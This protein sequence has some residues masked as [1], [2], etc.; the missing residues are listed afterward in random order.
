MPNEQDERPSARQVT[1]PVQPGAPPP[2]TDYASMES[3]ELFQQAM[4]PDRAA[5]AEFALKR[6]PLLALQGGGQRVEAQLRSLAAKLEAAGQAEQESLRLVYL[7]I[8]LL[9]WY[10]TRYGE[11]AE[12][13]QTASHLVKRAD[14]RAADLV[15]TDRTRVAK[16]IASEANRALAL[17]QVGMETHEIR[18][19]FAE[20]LSV[21]LPDKTP[22]DRLSFGALNYCA[23]RT[24][25]AEEHWRKAMEQVG[26][27]EGDLAIGAGINLATMF[28]E[29]GRLKKAEEV[30]EQTAKLYGRR[31]G[32]P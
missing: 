21:E 7:G 5:I 1:P 9:F 17:R 27:T 32:T 30:W 31:G 13:L 16:W 29:Q 15:A 3:D 22:L 14:E 28:I 26:D 24:A 23:G 10:L 18:G 19:L 4:T 11:A 12:V 8:G 2:G 25:Q 20:S 6:A